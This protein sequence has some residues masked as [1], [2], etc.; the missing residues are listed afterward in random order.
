MR[1]AWINYF[2]ALALLLT[3]GGA[4]AYGGYGGGMGHGMMGP[5]MGQGMMWSDPAQVPDEVLDMM[6]DH[7]ASMYRTMEQVAG[8][9]DVAK[10]RELVR[11]HM[12]EMQRYMW[13]RHG[14]LLQ[15]REQAPQ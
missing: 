15:R 1:S 13:E 4:L 9:D 5:G 6:A 12:I 2:L 8:T 7:M 3:A 14:E 11:Q 10:R